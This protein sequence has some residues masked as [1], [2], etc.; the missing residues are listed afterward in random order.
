MLKGMQKCG[1]SWG[2]I[3]PVTPPFVWWYWRGSPSTWPVNPPGLVPGWESN[4][5]YLPP[6][7]TG[8][9]FDG[10][11]IIP[12]FS[13]AIPRCDGSTPI[14]GNAAPI[15]DT[16]LPRRDGSKPIPGG[17]TP[18]CGVS[19]PR[20]C[21]ATPRSGVRKDYSETGKVVKGE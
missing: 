9:Q 7:Y 2:K 15:P 19:P 11:V 14:P 12:R 16:S 18:R 17:A 6:F 21:N 13:A 5:A 8:L 3:A 10:V 4:R 20:Y 1:K